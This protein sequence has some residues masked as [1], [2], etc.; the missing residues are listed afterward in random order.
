MGAACLF[1]LQCPD[2]TSGR[3]A[4]C[5]DSVYENEPGSS[6]GDIRPSD[7]PLKL[8]LQTVIAVYMLYMLY[9]LYCRLP[10]EASRGRTQASLQ[11]LQTV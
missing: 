8:R 1:I 5:T 9:M 2:R 11:M 6:R 10:V 7:V 4:F 3:P